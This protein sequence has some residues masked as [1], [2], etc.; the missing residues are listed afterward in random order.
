MTS[1]YIRLSPGERFYGQK[2]LLQSQI[3]VLNLVK[4]FKEFLS[5]RDEEL[6]LKVALKN[7]IAETL[8]F[9]ARLNKIL[10]KTKYKEEPVNEEEKIRHRERLSIQEEIDRIKNKLQ[11]LQS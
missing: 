4:G 11:K 6:M 3:E 5:L 2:Y 7:K 1:E 8:E 10:P 9:L